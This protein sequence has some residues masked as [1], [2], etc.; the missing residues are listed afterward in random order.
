[1]TYRHTP[2]LT[3]CWMT[4]IQAIVNATTSQTEQTCAQPLP[5][6][7]AY[8]DV[9]HC[10]HKYTTS[11]SSTY[12][13]Y[14]MTCILAMSTPPPPIPLSFHSHTV[15]LSALFLSRP[16][17][18]KQISELINT[19]PTRQC[20][21]HVSLT[22]YF[23]V[24]V[25]ATGSQ[26]VCLFKRWHFN[27]CKGSKPVTAQTLITVESHG[28]FPLFFTIILPAFFANSPSWL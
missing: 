17:T 11:S 19:Q 26:Q 16:K 2:T 8:D 9:L 27:W 6:R 23:P 21:H 14:W 13:E 5:A 7:S 25:S 22:H 18:D 3:E 1:M 10:R 20:H 24:A 28:L 15:L 4:C 12:T